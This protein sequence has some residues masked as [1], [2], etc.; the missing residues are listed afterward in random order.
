MQKLA[1]LRDC[2][3]MAFH[4]LQAPDR[5]GV[6][7]RLRLGYPGGSLYKKPG[8]STYT[9]DISKMRHKTR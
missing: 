4:T 7:R 8:E 2:L 1:L 9:V 3:I 6:V 5:V